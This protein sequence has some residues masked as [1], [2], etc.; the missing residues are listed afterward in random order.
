MFKIKEATTK[1][2]TKDVPINMALVI[3]IRNKVAKIVAFK[4]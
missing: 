2:K 4:N 1:P 3:I